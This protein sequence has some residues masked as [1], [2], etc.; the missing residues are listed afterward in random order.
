MKNIH[1]WNGNKSPVR[2]QY[3][4]EILTAALQATKSATNS[5][6]SVIID[7]TDYPSAKDEGNVFSNG[8]DVLVTV[9]GNLKFSNKAFIPINKPITKG[10]LGYRI[11]ITRKNFS[12]I[13]S[14]TLESTKQTIS[15]LKAGIPAT[16]ADAD[17]FRHNGF[18]VFEKGSFEEIFH[19]LSNGECDYVS[20]GA[21]E[22]ETVFESITHKFP[23]LIIEPD[24][25]LYYPFPLVFYVHPEKPEL[26][27][28]IELGLT[29]LINNGG[30]DEIF[31]R[32]FGECLDK[33]NLNNRDMVLLSNPI[34]P[35][36][37][38]GAITDSL[39]SS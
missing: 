5:K 31:D 34:L 14:H 24:L 7:T 15:T 3:E 33:L 23:N 30:L 18:Q 19:Y 11:L 1:F 21:N 10:L 16:W 36:A 39:I 22:V 17:L 38:D 27:K 13:I 26:A 29:Y 8:T 20:L 35:I 6:P 9:A 25:V 12:S 4:F 32:Y 2:Q 37:L 28:Q